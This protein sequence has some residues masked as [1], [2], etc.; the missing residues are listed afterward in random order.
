M[1]PVFGSGKNRLLVSLNR[2]IG[3][4]LESLRI[5]TGDTMEELVRRA[6]DALIAVDTASKTGNTITSIGFSRR[7][8]KDVTGP[9]MV[10]ISRLVHESTFDTDQMAG[11][12]LAISSVIS[13]I[14]KTH[15]GQLIQAV[16]IVFE[17][18]VRALRKDW[19]QIAQIPPEK[20]EEL[21]AAAFSRDGYDDVTITPRSGDLGRDVIAIKHGVGC[22]KVIGSVKRYA[23]GNLVSY[24]DVRALL[25]VLNGEQNSSKGLIV[26]TSDFPPHIRKDPFIS[27]FLPT[28]LELMNGDELR[29]WL[30][31]LAL[32]R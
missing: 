15:E 10:E 4:R 26:T 20:M 6:L 23:A 24:D 9:E 30:M 16:P 27:P 28:R 3:L 22:I 32:S 5:E 7:P 12:P 17:S 1:D 14:K 31:R 13:P 19:N 2:E 11:S 25:G 18:V 29:N 21:V 8:D